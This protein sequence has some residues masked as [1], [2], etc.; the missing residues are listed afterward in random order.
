[1]IDDPP[2]PILP[3]GLGM[4]SLELKVVFNDFRLWC[5]ALAGYNGR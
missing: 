1:M 2:A 3:L 5:T 4:G